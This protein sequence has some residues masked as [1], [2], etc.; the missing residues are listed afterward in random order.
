MLPP[1][2]TIQDE[3]HDGDLV[4][5]LMVEGQRTA[6]ATASADVLEQMEHQL[7]TTPAEVGQDLRGALERLH[8]NALDKVE[9]SRLREEPGGS[10]RFIASFVYRDFRDVVEGVVWYSMPDGRTGP[11]AVPALVRN[12]LR[13]E[14][15]TRL[16]GESKAASDLLKAMQ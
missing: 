11:D 3:S 7:G 2:V 8:A 16:V 15:H 5:A 6:T 12:K 10:R 14:V 9:I 4:L 13:Y 1:G